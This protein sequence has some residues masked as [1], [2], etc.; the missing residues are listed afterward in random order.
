MSKQE[1]LETKTLLAVQGL[2]N[3]KVY[4]ADQ[5]QKE[6]E[7]IVDSLTKGSQRILLA[8]SAFSMGLDVSCINQVI[9][10]NGSYSMLD[11]A[12]E[13]GRAGRRGEKAECN[14]LILRSKTENLEDFMKNYVLN[15]NACRRSI[16]HA[17]IDGCE[18]FCVQEN[19]ELCDICGPMFQ[20]ND[21]VP[22]KQSQKPPEKAKSVEEI[23]PPPIHSL[24]AKEV[25]IFRRKS[26]DETDDIFAKLK[27]LKAYGCVICSMELQKSSFHS[28]GILEC[29]FVLKKNL[30]LKCLGTNHTRQSCLFG[31]YVECLVI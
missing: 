31:K 3:I 20:E 22:L 18:A 17:Y 11:Y 2:E 15:N 12:Q 8:T 6:R 5:D 9:H 30:C 26:L 21:N 19:C 24:E 25:E 23:P 1:L 14:L 7:E 16:I 10:L 4:S 13:C 27:K 28:R 29:P